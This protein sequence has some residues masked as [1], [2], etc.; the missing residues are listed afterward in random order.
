MVTH[1]DHHAVEF[2]RLNPLWPPPEPDE[3]YLEYIFC[4][5][6]VVVKDVQTIF[7]HETKLQWCYIT[8]AHCQCAIEFC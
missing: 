3:W 7:L 6:L 5:H 2:H 8:Q 4:L 1:P